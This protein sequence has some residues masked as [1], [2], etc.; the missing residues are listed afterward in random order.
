MP[1]GL[2]VRVSPGTCVPVLAG[3]SCAGVTEQALAE[4]GEPTV[5]QQ[6][7]AQLMMRARRIES[8]QGWPASRLTRVRPTDA[9]CVQDEEQ[10]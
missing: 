1:A 4:E 6:I 7:P 3:C 9:V 2:C 8:W 10:H 5:V